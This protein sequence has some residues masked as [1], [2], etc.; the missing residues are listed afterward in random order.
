MSRS[1]IVLSDDQA[2]RLR[3]KMVSLIDRYPLDTEAPGRR[4][5]RPFVREFVR[6]IYDVTSQTY[7]PA[8][9]RKWI[10]LYAPGRGPSNDTLAKEKRALDRAL[11]EEANA[12][13]QINE[14]AASD[15]A[16]VVRRS[17]EE[18]LSD[19][20]A[21]MPSL[22]AAQNVGSSSDFLQDQLTKAQDDLKHVRVE[23]ARL[24][25][26][27]Q[28]ANAE[29]QLLQRQVDEARAARAE[30]ATVLAR[31]TDEL[32]GMRRFSMNAVEQVRGE[33]RAWKDKCAFFEGELKQAKVHLE[34]F[35]QIAYQ[36]G[37]TIPPDL[38]QTEKKE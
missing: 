15:L 19:F 38:R 23:A 7:S 9:Y 34:Y 6:T 1:R 35:R 10:E 12:G 17:I 2:Q 37:A 28:S 22:A 21:C 18:A 24:A 31:L 29:H 3:E 14:G 4:D 26:D 33:T 32:E 13:R 11:A 36:R 16:A 20:S 5:H 8:I 30:H 27:L 25:A